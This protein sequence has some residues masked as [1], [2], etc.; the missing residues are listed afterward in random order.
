MAKEQIATSVLAAFVPS[1]LPPE[2]SIYQMSYE[3]HVRQSS[4]V[5]ILQKR[6]AFLQDPQV[7]ASQDDPD[8]QS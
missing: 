4:V 5:Q 3:A 6:V 7:V 2:K 8:R 1:T